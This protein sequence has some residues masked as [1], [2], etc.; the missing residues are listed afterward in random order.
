MFT[1]NDVS[2]TARVHYVIDAGANVQ[3]WTTDVLSNSG[4]EVDV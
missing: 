1:R 2:G 4:T 3:E